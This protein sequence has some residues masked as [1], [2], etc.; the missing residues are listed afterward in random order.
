MVADA[1]MGL[2]F[3]HAYGALRNR[4]IALLALSLAWSDRLSLQKVVDGN[5]QSTDEG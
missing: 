3:H 1:A 4:M 5:G 2:T